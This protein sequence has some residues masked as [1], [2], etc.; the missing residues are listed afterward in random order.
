MQN[1][2]RLNNDLAN[3]ILPDSLFFGKKEVQPIDWAK[4]QYNTFYRNPDYFKG[5]FHKGIDKILPPEFFEKMAQNAM[6][7]AEEM[8]FRKA[9]PV[10][11][12]EVG[13]EIQ[14]EEN[15]ISK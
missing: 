8:D 4:V 6:T 5:K 15:D 2:R 13:N 3:G 9:V 7:P 1:I 10:D 11:L 12:Y 14:I